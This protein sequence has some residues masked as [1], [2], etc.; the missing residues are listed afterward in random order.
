MKHSTARHG[1]PRSSLLR[2]APARPD[3]T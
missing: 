3:I 1:Q 2:L